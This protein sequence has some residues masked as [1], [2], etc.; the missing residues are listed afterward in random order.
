MIDA[1]WEAVLLDFAKRLESR[2]SWC[3]ETHWQKS[4]YFLQELAETPLGFDFLF[5][6]HGPYS[7][8]LSDAITAMRGNELVELKLEPGFGPHV[9]PTERS[10]RQIALFPKTCG[11][12][13]KAMD[14]VAERL[15]TKNVAQLE[16][17]STALYVQKK[18]HGKD[19][20]WQSKKVN[21]LKPHVS[22]SDARDALQE[23]AS[24]KEA[25]D[26]VSS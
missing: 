2:G 21:D 9:V 12:Y 23:V 15:A 10:S 7:F 16:R 26:R 14:F 17:L 19:E 5:Y 8:D 18:W 24:F 6:K 20:E 25:W 1:K 3:G 13:R 4:V 22:I 11:K